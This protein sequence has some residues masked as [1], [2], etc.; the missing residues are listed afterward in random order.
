NDPARFNDLVMFDFS[1]GL[2]PTSVT[3]IFLAAT[4]IEDGRLHQAL[5]QFLGTDSM[6]V[7]SPTEL[8][9]LVKTSN[10]VSA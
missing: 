6:K 8:E 4:F 9:G 2:S 5:N 3:M 1:Q 10:P 7:L